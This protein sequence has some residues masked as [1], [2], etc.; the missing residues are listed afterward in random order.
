MNGFISLLIYRTVL[1]HSSVMPLRLNK[2]NSPL[3]AC[4]QLLGACDGSFYVST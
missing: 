2:N 4:I 1:I 3:L